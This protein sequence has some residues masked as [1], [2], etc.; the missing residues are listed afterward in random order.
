VSPVASDPQWAIL[1][2]DDD[3]LYADEHQARRVLAI[4]DESAEDGCQLYRLAPDRSDEDLA[5]ALSTRLQ[6]DFRL[7]IEPNTRRHITD[8]QERIRLSLRECDDVAHA[9]VAALRAATASRGDRA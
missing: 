9:A 3:V 6:R 7:R 2:S 8:G 4:M 5:A 1:R